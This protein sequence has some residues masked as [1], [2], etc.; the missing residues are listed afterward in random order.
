MDNQRHAFAH[1]RG[2]PTR[3]GSNRLDLLPPGFV[4]RFYLDWKELE[5]QIQNLQASKKSMLAN[6][7]A[8]YGRHQ[9]EALKITMRRALMD[10]KQRAEQATFNEMA[11]HYT[12]LLET[13][14]DARIGEPD[15]LRPVDQRGL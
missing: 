1:A 9:A 7:R 8:R 13:E 6:I 3:E 12:D 14:I 11:N 2:A 5:V 4:Y 10:K 15:L